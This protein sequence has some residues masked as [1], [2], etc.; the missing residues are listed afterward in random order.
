MEPWNQNKNALCPYML[1]FVTSFSCDW[2]L[3]GGEIC[4]FGW[5]L[6]RTKLQETVLTLIFLFV[7]GFPLFSHIPDQSFLASSAAFLG[8]LKGA[9]YLHDTLKPS[10]CAPWAIDSQN[11]C[12][13]NSSSRKWLRGSCYRKSSYYSYRFGHWHLHNHPANRRQAW[14]FLQQLLRIMQ[15][16]MWRRLLPLMEQGIPILQQSK[17]ELKGWCLPVLLMVPRQLPVPLK[18][19]HPLPVVL[20]LP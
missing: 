4:I 1:C 13:T 2:L 12:S 6:S 15:V 14:K 9:C 3:R 11:D 19:L 17:E 7:T 16:Y 18:R 5:R 8:Q 20:L 10:V